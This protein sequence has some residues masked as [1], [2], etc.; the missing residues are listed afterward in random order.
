MDLNFSTILEVGALVAS[1][2]SAYTTL[3][4]RATML[5]LKLW[6]TENF[7]RRRKVTTPD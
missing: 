3:G 4:T 6:V 2:F 5:E 7:E 1:L